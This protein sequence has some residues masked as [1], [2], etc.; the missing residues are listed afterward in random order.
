MITRN[1]W[2]LLSARLRPDE[3]RSAHRGRA[4]RAGRGGRSDRLQGDRRRHEDPPEKR[5]SATVEFN[6]K[7]TPKPKPPPKKVDLAWPTFGY[8]NARTKVSPYPHRPPFHRTWKLNGHN[9][10]EFPP[11]AAFGNVYLAQQ[12]GLFFA[13][14]G[15]T[16]KKVFRTKHFK[17]CAA[18]SPT[19]ANDTIYQAYMDWVAVPAGRVEPDRLR[20]RDERQDRAA[21]VDLPPQAVRVEPAAPQGNPVRRQLGR[22]RLRDPRARRQEGLAP[23]RPATGSTPRPP[24]PTGA[25]SS[26]TT[27]G[28]LFALDARTGKQIW[29]KSDATEFFYATPVTAY[30][31]V[32]IGGTDGTM[33]S[34]GQKTGNLLWAK[35]LGTYIYSSA[36]VYKRRVFTG[37][38]DGKLYALDAAT[39][40]T[41]WRRDVPSAVHGSPVVMGGLV[42]SPTARAAAPRRRATSSTAPRAWPPTTSVTGTACGNNG[43]KFASPIIADEDRVYL[44]GRDQLFALVPV[45]RDRARRGRSAEGGSGRDHRAGQRPDEVVVVERP[46]D[47]E[48][49]ED[50]DREAHGRDPGLRAS[51]SACTSSQAVSGSQVSTA[52]IA[53]GYEPSRSAMMRADQEAREP[54]AD[55]LVGAR[56]VAD[57]VVP[58]RPRVG[59]QERQ[60]HDRAEPREHR[61]RAL[62]LGLAR[63]LVQHE[64]REE[65]QRHD[66]ELLQQH[67]RR[68]GR[69]RPAE[70]P[71]GGERE[72]EDHQRQARRVVLTEPRRAHGDRVAGDEQRRARAAT[73]GGRGTRARR[74]ARRG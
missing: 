5:G 52:K 11:S 28:T 14:N 22:E 46:A 72:G 33:Y 55:D 26:P 9:A 70:A 69:R 32:Y 15:K 73:R 30:G 63:A 68:E 65:R 64:D 7:D 1:I 42:Y 66:R 36:A 60:R 17:R 40:D 58:E 2:R 38:Y 19:L 71:A 50:G 10:L 59:D 25:S 24:T 4:P 41:R 44:T 67:R 56:A 57:G 13:V 53:N 39:G 34:Y 54:V 47:E 49:H 43:G 20:D 16:G 45:H 21:P 61:A 31:R 6:A 27:A 51:A 62:E 74:T 8:D 18:S 37:T 12:K 48:Q 29:S 23:T 3:T 35:P